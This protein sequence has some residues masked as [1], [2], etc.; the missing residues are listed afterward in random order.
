MPSEESRYKRGLGWLT[1]VGQDDNCPKRPVRYT[2]EM[3]P[4]K[5]RHMSCQLHQVTSAGAR[6]L[7]TPCC[8][9]DAAIDVPSGSPPKQT[10]DTRK[11]RQGCQT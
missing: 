10:D 3:A 11:V 1:M 8:Q 9:N 7:R 2:R 4:P 5:Q 6:K